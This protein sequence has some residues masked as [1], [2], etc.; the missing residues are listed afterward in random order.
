MPTMKDGDNL[1]F[2][3]TITKTKLL[4]QNHSLNNMSSFRAIKGKRLSSTHQKIS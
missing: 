1:M 2:C 3:E 4:Y